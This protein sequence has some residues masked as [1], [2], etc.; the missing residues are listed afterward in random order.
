MPSALESL[1]EN[2]T[3][4]E[5]SERSGRPVGAIVEWALGSG[6]GRA[7]APAKSKGSN[8]T[9]R[10]AKAKG[11]DVRTP[12]GRAAYDDAVLD[13]V[14][15]AKSPVSA[16]AVRAKVGGTPPQARAA[17]NRLIESGKVGYTGRARATRYFIK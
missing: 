3:L 2:M 14:G 15:G 12:K 13:I 5:L 4:R 9:P 16:Q 17:L 7:A 8:G 6:A 1:V 11:V 10:P